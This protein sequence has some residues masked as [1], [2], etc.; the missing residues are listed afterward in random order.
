MAWIRTEQGAINPAYFSGVLVHEE[1]DAETGAAVFVVCAERA[2]GQHITV[3]ARADYTEARSICD[4][5]VSHL[6][7][8]DVGA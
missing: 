8:A 6:A 4:S 3:A 5:I 2:D 1:R 7:G